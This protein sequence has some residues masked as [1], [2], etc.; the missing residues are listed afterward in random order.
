VPVERFC[1]GPG[2]NVL[3][4]DEMLVSLFVPAP[5]RGFGAHYLRFIP[6]NEM[7]IAVVGCGAS[8]E[9]GN[10][11]SRFTAARVALGAVAPTPLLVDA[12]ATELV[13][14][15][16]GDAAIDRAAAAA[17]SA[18]RPIDDM[19]GTAE[20]RRHLAGVLTRRALHEAVR[21]A[22]EVTA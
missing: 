16:V 22:Q 19:R 17:Q 4:P 8:V 21:R 13:D 1:T 18:C 14:H 20:F 2:R 9:L 15:P 12:A 7:D 10:G 6:R 11:G 5:A 3:A